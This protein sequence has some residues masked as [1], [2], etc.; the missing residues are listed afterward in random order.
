MCRST[1]IA[2]L[3]QIDVH[4]YKYARN[5][6]MWNLGTLDCLRPAHAGIKPADGSVHVEHDELG[7][8]MG[9]QRP[10]NFISAFGLAGKKSLS[11]VENTIFAIPTAMSFGTDRLNHRYFDGIVITALE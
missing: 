5:K 3:R 6:L 8:K 10:Q 7:L 9:I 11:P 2:V 1:A 4:A